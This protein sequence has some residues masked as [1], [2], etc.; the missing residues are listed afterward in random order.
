VDVKPGLST[1]GK[2]M[3]ENIERTRVHGA[4]FGLRCREKRNGIM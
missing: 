2:N 3:V 1:K 4:M